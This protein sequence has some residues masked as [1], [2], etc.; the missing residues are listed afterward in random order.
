VYPEASLS[1]A[2]E[3]RDVAK[4]LLADGDDPSV[5]KKLLKFKQGVIIAPIMLVFDGIW[6]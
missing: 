3:K 5:A 1:K 4:R 6:A 2:R